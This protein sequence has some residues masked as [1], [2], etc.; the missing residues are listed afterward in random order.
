MNNQ[1][2]SEQ[3]HREVE[4]IFRDLL[5]QNGRTVREEQIALC[6]AMLDTLLQNN[7]LFCDAGT[8]IGKTDAYRL[9]FIPA[10]PACKNP[11]SSDLYLQRCLAGRYF[12]NLSSLFIPRFSP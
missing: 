2:T 8:G 3:M 5:P 10:V 6:H 12:E 7:I 9:Y 11:A 1:Q 4:R